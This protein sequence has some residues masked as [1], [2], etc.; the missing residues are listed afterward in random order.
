M[1]E[2]IIVDIYCRAATDDQFDLPDRPNS[3]ENQEKAC[4]AYCEQHDLAVAIV[5][6][7]VASGIQYRERE[8]LNL[9]RRRIRGGEIQG[10]VVADLRRLSCSQVHLIVLLEEMNRHNV[11]LYTVNE[12]MD[13]TLMGRCVLTALAL[14]AEV[15]Q[16]K[17]LDN[18][19]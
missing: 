13:I 10:V 14:I 8:Q 5:Y 12:D 15:E 1:P 2:P 9:M 19:Q 6:S 7:E 4:R 18:E 16:E 3:L 11:K 17:S